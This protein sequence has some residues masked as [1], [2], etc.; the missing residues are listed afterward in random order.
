M[1]DVTGPEQGSTKFQPGQSG[2]P[3]GRP[4]GARSKLSESF[5]SALADD[6]DEHGVRVI[7]EVRAEKPA[8]YLKVIA[9]LVPKEF[10][11]PDGGDIPL[12]LTVRF[13]RSS[14]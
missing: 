14:S 10:S 12:G 8:D 7:Q 5:L 2:N 9:A 3:A 6:F 13:V 1:P 4:K 11:G